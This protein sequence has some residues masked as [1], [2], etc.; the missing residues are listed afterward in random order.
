MK[1]SIAA[2]KVLP[3][4]ALC[5]FALSSDAFAIGQARYVEGVAR[6]GSFAIAQGKAAA[7]L[8]VGSSDWAGV[9]RAVND[10]QADIERVT[11][12]KSPVSN[13]AKALKTN[14]IIVGTVGKSPII[15]R[16]IQD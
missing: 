8:Y 14:A 15:D 10:L 3:V 6:P 9:V 11:G 13:D 7:T 4:S 2:T 1:F 5:I 12:V 16:L